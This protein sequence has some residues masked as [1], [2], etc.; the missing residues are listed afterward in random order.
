MMDW[1]Y[2]E[3]STVPIERAVLPSLKERHA[4]VSESRS[5]HGIGSASIRADSERARLRG[6]ET[7]VMPS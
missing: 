1:L 5:R 3:G 7:E 4:A 6:S 2:I